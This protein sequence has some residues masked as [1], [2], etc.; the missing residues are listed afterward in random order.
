[1]K[2]RI[3]ELEVDFIGGQNDPLTK[4]E[5]LSISDFIKQLKEKRSTKKKLRTTKLKKETAQQ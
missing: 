1:M 4:E 3:K 2:K 5:Q